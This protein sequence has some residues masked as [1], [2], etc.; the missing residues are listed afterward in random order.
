[1][2]INHIRINF[3]VRPPFSFLPLFISLLL[4]LIACEKEEVP[5]VRIRD[6]SQI[7][8]TSAKVMGNV[9]S[10]G[11][12]PI[13]ERGVVWS[14]S[15]NPT[16]EDNREASGSGT[17]YF[18][19]SLSGLNPNTK[20]YVRVYAVNSEGTSYGS[21]VTFTTHE[22][23]YEDPNVI[24]LGPNST[25]TLGEPAIS[26]IE[27][28]NSVYNEGPSKMNYLT[29]HVLFP[30]DR[31]NQE[32]IEIEFVPADKEVVEDNR[33]QEN[34]AF[35]EFNDIDSG[36]AVTSYWRAKVETR[37]LNYNIDPHDV[38]TLGDIPTDVA[39]EYLVDEDIYQIHD[40]VVVNARDEA[41]EGETHPL[42]MAKKI[43]HWVQDHM[44]Y[45]TGHGWRDAPSNIESG[46]GTCS[47][48]AYAFIAMCRSAG[49]PA[50][51][52][53]A[54]VRR[55]DHDDAGPHLDQPKHRWAQVYLPDIGWIEANVQGGN[56]GV[57][58]ERYLII[59]ESSGTSDLLGERYDAYR[60]WSFEND[61][62]TERERY[63]MWWPVNENY[64]EPEAP[65]LTSPGDD[66]EDFG[67]QPLKW[68]EVENAE[69]YRV[70]I[71]RSED[72]STLAFYDPDVPDT[73]RFPQWAND[74]DVTYYWRVSAS[75][76]GGT[77]E[78]SEVRS[79]KR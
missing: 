54:L 53:G 3:I 45:E 79:F 31:P 10:D 64:S 42:E 17:G 43:F 49:L 18:S 30:E 48:W 14:K 65:V 16:M 61:G 51:W 15:S 77:S 69:S 7:T 25:L 46:V 32:V 19:V 23:D 13:T 9:S 66:E 36:M 6:I 75:N 62:S 34:I 68:K 73:S 56:W 57:L 12:A 60:R 27:L 72:F 52:S 5:S 71:S 67:N 28:I 2:K 21:Q 20:Y 29:F 8:G 59:S 78:W 35:Y 4:L 38:G 74:E 55:G 44:T 24:S 1:M 63:G 22:E 41:L 39:D 50:R 70:Q 11:G 47:G 33:G 37:S 58:S 76:L 26:D 40:P